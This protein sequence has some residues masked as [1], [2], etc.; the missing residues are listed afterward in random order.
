MDAINLYWEKLLGP[1]Y[2]VYVP[3]A[4]HDLAMDW[5]RVFGAI[6]GLF[7]AASGQ[8]PLPEMHWEYE[9]TEDGVRLTV[10][11]DEAGS[12]IR[13]WSASSDTRDFRKAVWDSTVIEADSTGSYVAEVPRPEE[14][15]V[16]VYAEVTY[17][18]GMLPLHLATTVRVLGGSE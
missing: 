13:L 11:L 8:Q 3:N 18:R 16:A 12:Q 14:G 17:P 5:Q 4:D 2:V 6:R 1:K 15:Y 9:P 7:L 10:N